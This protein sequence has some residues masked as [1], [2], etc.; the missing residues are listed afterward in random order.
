MRVA[1]I[2]I[3]TNSVLLL[4]ADGHASTLTPVAESSTI[5]RLGQG[6]D[7]SGQLHPQAID[8]TLTCLAQYAK[9]I[10]KHNVDRFDVVSTSAARDARGTD[11][12]LAKAQ[13]VLGIRPRVVSGETEAQ[14]SFRGAL[15]GLPIEGA[16]AVYDV[17]GGST[18]VV[19]GRSNLGQIPTIE[20]ATS[21][22]IGCVRLTERH[23]CS[24]PPSQAELGAIR[25]DVLEKLSLISLPTS[26]CT[27]IGM[28]GTITTL[29]AIEKAM[30][31]Y[32][33]AEIHGF[34]LTLTE[35]ERLG[36]RLE[37]MQGDKRREVAGLPPAR[38]DVIVTGTVLIRELLGWAKQST[39]LVSNR[40]VRW[41]LALE[42]C[43][44]TR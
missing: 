11:V 42:L 27:W 37:T 18:E 34:H 22:D 7:R 39:T 40:G 30:T 17:G 26:P 6:V 43:G 36:K 23:V 28:G 15:T 41:G 12:F 25:R 1:T 16:I 44:P 10:K 2:D 32:D 33:A 5:T 3:G 14:L 31:T 8:R 35:I 4:I 19:F 21:V 13:E 9:C 20:R 38:A 24:D 29:A